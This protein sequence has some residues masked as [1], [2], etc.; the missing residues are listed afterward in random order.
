MPLLHR[1]ISGETLTDSTHKCEEVEEQA[2]PSALGSP[3]DFAQGFAP[4]AFD[5]PGLRLLKLGFRLISSVS[6]RLTRAGCPLSRI[7]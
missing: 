6:L 1:P 5:S 7:L 3:F 4:R 2:S